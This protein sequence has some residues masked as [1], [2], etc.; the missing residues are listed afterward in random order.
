MNHK[1]N[2]PPL[3]ELLLICRTL[4]LVTSVTDGVRS[5]NAQKNKPCTCYKRNPTY[6]SQHIV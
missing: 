6:N 1:T 4:Q 5:I 3:V 2:T